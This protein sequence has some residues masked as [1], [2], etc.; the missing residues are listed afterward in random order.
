M[1]KEIVVPKQPVK[2]YQDFMTFSKWS[3]QYVYV[4]RIYALVG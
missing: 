4:R 2:T 3:N 1:K